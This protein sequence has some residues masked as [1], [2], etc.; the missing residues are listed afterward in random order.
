[1]VLISRYLDH[2]KSSTL[3]AFLLS[4]RSFYHIDNEGRLY[5]CCKTNHIEVCRRT[6][7]RVS[8]FLT[9]HVMFLSIDKSAKRVDR[10]SLVAQTFFLPKN[11]HKIEL[12][13]S[14]MC[15]HPHIRKRDH[16]G[17]LLAIP[18]S[19]FFGFDR[20]GERSFKHR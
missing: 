1:M 8:S 11:V 15:L 4:F 12:C 19:V 10:Y 2:C 18:L 6:L 13:I 14:K 9:A 5:T 7:L 3:N 20:G 17:N 16:H